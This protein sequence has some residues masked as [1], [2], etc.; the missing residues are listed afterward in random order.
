MKKTYNPHFHII[1]KDRYTAEVL[2]QEWLKL[3]TTKFTNRKGQN[4]QKVT[5]LESGLIEIIKYGSKIF[6]EPDLKKRDKET[7]T[8]CIYIKALDTILT[9]MKGKRIFDRFGFNLSK[10]TNLEKSNPKL[11]FDYKEWEYNLKTS[12]WVNVMTGECLSGYNTPPHL[13]AL[14]ENNIDI[15]TE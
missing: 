11:L 4:I 12:D 6:T 15:E 13:F 10:E 5:N 7:S 2:L 9:A 14:L 1:T 3:W 8:A